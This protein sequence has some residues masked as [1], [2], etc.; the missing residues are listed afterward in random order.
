M[1]QTENIYEFEVSSLEGGELKFS[2]FKGKMILIVNTAS[3]CGYTK[4]YA[5]L[6]ELFEAHSDQLVIVGFPANN[7]LW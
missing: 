4:Q 7:F 2:E 3:E 1:S 5:Q 6:E